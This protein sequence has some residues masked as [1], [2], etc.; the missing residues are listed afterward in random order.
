MSPSR[1][2]PA[3]GLLTRGRIPT[4]LVDLVLAGV[5][6]PNTRR[7]YAK[8]IADL[9]AFAAREDGSCQPI[10]LAL[11]LEWRATMAGTLSSSTVN[12]RLSAVR[13]LI[14][15]GTRAGLVSAEEAFTLLQLDGLPFRGTRVGNWLTVQQARK[16]LSLP[17][18]SN[19]RGL[20][21]YC[22]LALLTGCALR[23][24]ELTTIE[25][26]TLQQRDG[27]WVLADLPG[28]GG[29]VRTVAVPDWVCKAILDW[30]KAAKIKEG[31][32]IRQLTLAPE[33]LS[34]KAVWDIVHKAAAKVGIPNFGPHDLRRT[35]ARLCREQGGDIEQIQAMLGHASIVTTQRYLGTVQNL[36]NAVNDNMGL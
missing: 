22:I 32:L 7:N 15:A 21:N 34:T 18:R 23:E 30:I 14:K 20:R 33:G 36:K 16:L 10:T 25:V 19:L 35:C 1:V 29:R 26:A 11:L 2:K 27:R 9:Y 3:S 5:A 6:S 12:V 28:K 31:K 17:S 13:H 8:G 4:S 24:D